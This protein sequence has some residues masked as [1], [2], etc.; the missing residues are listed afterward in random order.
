MHGIN[1]P[2]VERRVRGLDGTEI[3]YYIGGSGARPFVVA[4]GLGTPFITWK[5][6]IEELGDE[7]R[8]VTWDPRGTYRSAT[9]SDTGHLRLEDHIGDMVSICEAEGLTS[10]PLGGWS[11]GVQI[12]L[13][14]NHRFPKSTMALVLIGGAYQHVLSTAF[15]M[16]G[17]GC[18]V[19]NALRLARLFIPA[20]GPV[21]S[22][23]LK[24]GTTMSLLELTGMVTN[25]IEHF[26]LMAHQFSST[27]WDIYL[28]LILQLNEHSAA[29]YLQDVKVPA[30]VVAGAQDRLTPISVSREMYRGIPGSRLFVVPRGTHYLVVEYPEMVNLQIRNFLEESAE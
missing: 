2:V 19:P 14:Y 5:Y 17:A 13:E 21:A 28:K 10:F 23:L 4:P 3:A 6:L 9:P 1:A 7:Y 27:D 26:S 8:I 22:G 15:G 24:S 20:L 30:L 29:S 18:L 16:P 12:C 25:N 11:M